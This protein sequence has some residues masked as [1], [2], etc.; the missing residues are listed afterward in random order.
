MN[1]RA[2]WSIEVAAGMMVGAAAEWQEGLLRD[3]RAVLVECAGG[4]S[5]HADSYIAKI[6]A[7]YAEML[8]TSSGSAQ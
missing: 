3:I 7:R 2:E 4:A 6:R 5:E 1:P 8:R